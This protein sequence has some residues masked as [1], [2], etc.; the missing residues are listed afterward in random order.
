MTM[1]AWAPMMQFATFLLPLHEMLFFHVSRKQLHT[2][3]STTFHSFH[4]QVD[5]W[6]TKD[7]IHTLVIV[8]IADPT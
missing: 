1:S 6:F 8:V 5:I 2:L 7:G 4:Q 3:L